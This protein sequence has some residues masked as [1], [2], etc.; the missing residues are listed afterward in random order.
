MDQFLKKSSIRNKSLS[1]EGKP[2][3]AHSGTVN[4]HCVFCCYFLSHSIN[5]RVIVKI[6]GLPVF[7]ERLFDSLWQGFNGDILGASHQHVKRRFQFLTDFGSSFS[8]DFCVFK[9]INQQARGQYLGF[10]NFRKIFRGTVPPSFYIR[11][12]RRC[13]CAFRLCFLK[14]EHPPAEP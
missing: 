11:H 12:I 5:C 1:Q 14:T 2:F 7:F 6:R 3:S 4:F 8:L 13:S 9:Q 10:R